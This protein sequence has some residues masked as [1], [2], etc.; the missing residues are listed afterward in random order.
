MRKKY[1]NCRISYE[2]NKISL[3][4]YKDELEEAKAELIKISESSYQNEPVKWYYE[5]RKNEWRTFPKHLNI[6]IESSFSQKEKK[7]ISNIRN[8]AIGLE[9]EKYFFK[10]TF[11]NEQNVSATIDFGVEPMQYSYYTLKFNLARVDDAKIS[12]KYIFNVNFF[13]LKLN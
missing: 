1:K 2:G 3:H 6:L 5:E 9:I 11:A 10:F 13:Y 4:G 8:F 7:V 12:K